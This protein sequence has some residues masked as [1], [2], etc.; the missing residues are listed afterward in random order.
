MTI[1][2]LEIG[3]FYNADGE[4]VYK[5]VDIGVDWVLV[6]VY[7]TVHYVCNAEFYTIEEFLKD[8]NKEEN[9]WAE[10]LFETELIYDNW[11]MLKNKE[12]D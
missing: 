1:E 3:K 8:F 6:L 5:L 12:K 10:D 7:S 2:D 11:Q 9:E 4:A